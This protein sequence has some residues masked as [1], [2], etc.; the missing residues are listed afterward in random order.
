MKCQLQ[1]MRTL[2]Q[3]LDPDFCAF[4]EQKES[5]NMYFCFRWLLIWFKREFLFHDIKRLW[6][7]MWTGLP[8]R[9]FVLLIACAILLKERAYITENDLSF[10]DILKYVN[11]LSEKM[12]IDEIVATG[13]ALFK[14]LERLKSQNSLNKNIISI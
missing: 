7:I 13:C 2:L 6:E 14:M 4:L 12:D 8:C 3:F 1:Q 11:G 5:L 9:N 10:T